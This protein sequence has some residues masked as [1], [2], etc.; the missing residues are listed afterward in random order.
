MVVVE[1]KRPKYSPDA[2]KIGTK[3]LERGNEIYEKLDLL[4]SDKEGNSIY[5]SSMNLD[6]AY[7]YMSAAELRIED[8]Y[9]IRTASKTNGLFMDI[10]AVAKR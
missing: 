8:Y 1:K 7:C 3:R 4:E 6:R 10:N 5:Y 9:L 2:P